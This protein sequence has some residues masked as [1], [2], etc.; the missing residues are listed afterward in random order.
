MSSSHDSQSAKAICAGTRACSGVL[1]RLI[2]RSRR[3]PA[4]ISRSSDVNARV[5]HISSD[6]KPI[7][8]F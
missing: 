5:L 6:I 1:K 8:L 4:R 3:I 2:G 7:N